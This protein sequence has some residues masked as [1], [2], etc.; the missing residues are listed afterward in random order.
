MQI[1]MGSYAILQIV[2][3]KHYKTC[4]ILG[5]QDKFF[6]IVKYWEEQEWEKCKCYTFY[7]YIRILLKLIL[8]TMLEI[9]FS[10]KLEAI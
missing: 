5:T 10:L 7:N 3:I 1:Q 8:W 2:K 9:I 4:G 6:K